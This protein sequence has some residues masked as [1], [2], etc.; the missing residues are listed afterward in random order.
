LIKPSLGPRELAGFVLAGGRSSRMGTDK[1]LIELAGKP[2]IDHAVTRLRRICGSVHI[3]SSN[4]A[5]A[6]YGH[7]VPD[8]HPGCGPLGGIEA[9][10]SATDCDWNV[11]LAV[12]MPFLPTALVRALVFASSGTE[13]AP[14]VSLLMDDDRPQPGFCLL[15]REVLAHVSAAIVRG[16][17]KLMRVFEEIGREVPF[18]LSCFRLSEMEFGTSELSSAGLAWETISPAQEAARSLWFANFNTPDEYAL[19]AAHLDALD[20]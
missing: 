5:L 20:T 3:L 1:A 19:A 4:A 11:F 17:L 7:L 16:D 14:R 12:D 9:G 15:H 13:T 8:I 18:G 2:L 10:L 6:A